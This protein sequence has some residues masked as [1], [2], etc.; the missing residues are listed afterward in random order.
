MKKSL[1][2]LA[3]GTLVLGIAEFTMMGILS[4]VA[5]DL[6]ISIPASGHLISAYALGA[7]CGAPVLVLAPNRCL[8][9]VWPPAANYWVE[10]V[11]K[12]PSTWAMPLTPTWVDWP[13]WKATATLP[14]WALH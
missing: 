5:D 6:N 8:S 12:W 11:Y 14:S 9:Y 7:C 2:A 4:Y 1:I 10:H 13:S 3:F